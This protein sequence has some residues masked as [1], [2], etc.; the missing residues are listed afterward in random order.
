MRDSSRVTETSQA[1]RHPRGRLPR[2]AAAIAVAAALSR[3]AWT[4]V[5]QHLSLHTDVVGSP[6]FAD[7]DINRYLDAYYLVVIGCPVLAIAVY[8]ALWRW[9]P[10]R[11]RH[12][13]EDR[14]PKF[15]P[16]DKGGQ[17]EKSSAETSSRKRLNSSTI[18]SSFT[19]SPSNS[20]ADSSITS[21]AA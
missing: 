20:I 2:F 10:L 16:D 18:S 1:D 21:S 5:P 15:E 17:A 14:S 12:V 3:V 9:G 11:G 19:S 8:Y 13:L 4:F 6:T 7:F